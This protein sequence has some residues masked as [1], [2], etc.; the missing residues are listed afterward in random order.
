MKVPN[1]LKNWFFLPAAI[2]STIG[3]ITWGVNSWNTYLKKQVAK[4]NRQVA[5]EE[6]LKMVPTWEATMNQHQLRLNRLER[7]EG[8]PTPEVP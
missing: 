3:L 4:E 5:I 2:L 7:R 1:W 8:V 6:A